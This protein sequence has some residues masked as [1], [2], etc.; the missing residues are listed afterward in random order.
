[1]HRGAASVDEGSGYEM[2]CGPWGISLTQVYV[3]VCMFGVRAV[4][5]VAETSAERRAIFF[6]S[7]TLASWRARSSSLEACS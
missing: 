3:R 7:S 1:M 5:V 2:R 4:T 6:V